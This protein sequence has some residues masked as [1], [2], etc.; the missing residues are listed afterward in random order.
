MR[1]PLNDRLNCAPIGQSFV[2]SHGTRRLSQ[3]Q[4]PMWS[5]RSP[6][7]HTL[8]RHRPCI[9]RSTSILHPTLQAIRATSL[10]RQP[11]LALS[12]VSAWYQKSIRLGWVSCIS[13]IN[14]TRRS[15][16]P[17]RRSIMGGSRLSRRFPRRR[18]CRCKVRM[19]LERPC[20]GILTQRRRVCTRMASTKLI[21]PW[22]IRHNTSSNSNTSSSSS[23]I[24]SNTNNNNSSISS[25]TLNSLTYMPIRT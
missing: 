23:N 6:I 2:S 13:N 5:N 9:L 24:S 14:H 8:A 11:W 21:C 25:S 3:L 19:A 22:R 12:R 10:T 1:K 4:H 15:N 18:R 20:V 7:H 17:K 16:T